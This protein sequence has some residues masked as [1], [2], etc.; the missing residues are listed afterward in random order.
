MKYY[1]LPPYQF[2]QLISNTWQSQCHNIINVLIMTRKTLLFFGRKLKTRNNVCGEIWMA[3]T[4][5]GENDNKFKVNC[6]R[7]LYMKQSKSPL[8]GVMHACFSSCTFCFYNERLVQFSIIW[9]NK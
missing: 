7:Y 8:V 6:I 1:V 4:L 3:H 2:E 9:R 5:L